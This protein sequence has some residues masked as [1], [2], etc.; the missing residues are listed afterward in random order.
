M[1]RSFI[2]SAQFNYLAEPFYLRVGIEL[3]DFAA[4]VGVG[5][6]QISAFN[7]LDVHVIEISSIRIGRLTRLVVPRR[8]VT[9]CTV[10]LSVK[11]VGNRLGGRH[12]YGGKRES[13]NC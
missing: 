3:R 13:K 5:G 2:A 12:S 1:G 6:A 7:F 8:Q 11:P 4:I 9:R 10:S